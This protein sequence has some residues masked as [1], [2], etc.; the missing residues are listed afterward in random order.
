MQRGHYSAPPQAPAMAQ[1]SAR[2]PGLRRH[3]E[4]RR[5]PVFGTG[6][7]RHV[8]AVERGIFPERSDLDPTVT[9]RNTIDNDTGF[10]WTGY[11]VNVFMDNPFTVSAATIYTP[12][13]SE[14]GWTGSITVSPAVLVGSQYE[15]RKWITWA[16]RRFLMAAQSTSAT[17]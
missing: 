9:M 5:K 17:K 14:P 1:S 3:D 2:V 12:A 10:S 8:A 13:T 6:R 7:Y 11:H 15:G 16:A 4:H